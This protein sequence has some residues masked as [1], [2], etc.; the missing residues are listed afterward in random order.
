MRV[1]PGL[2]VPEENGDVVR[3]ADLDIAEVG[4][5]YMHITRVSFGFRFTDSC[6]LLSAMVKVPKKG[7]VY[8]FVGN[9]DTRSTRHLSCGEPFG[10]WWKSSECASSKCGA[11][12]QQKSED[13]LATVQSEVNRTTRKR[14]RR[15]S[16]CECCW[17]IQCWWN[18]RLNPGV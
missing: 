2:K 6:L 7:Q 18:E 14:H 4:R 9:R 5:R 17:P 3:L 1:V 11:G 10:L 15:I 12:N 13:H 16:E 8:L